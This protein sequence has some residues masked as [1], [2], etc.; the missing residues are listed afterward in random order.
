MI[1]VIV[2]LSLFSCS[3]ENESVNLN[4]NLPYYEFNN[5][6]FE[7]LLL[8][9]EDKGEIIIFKNQENEELHFRVIFSK[10]EKVEYRT[11]TFW[12]SYTWVEFYYDRQLIELELLDNVVPDEKFRFIANK[13]SENFIQ[14][15]INFPLWNDNTSTGALGR[16]INIDLDYSTS[17]NQVTIDGILYKKVIEFNSRFD[18]APFSFGNMPRNVAKIIYDLNKGIIGFNDLENNEWRIVNKI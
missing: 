6:D 1:Y 14:G 9:Y 16:P 15:G 18:V 17:V 7:N 4:E 13:Y 11:G 8:V 2:I 12:S 5:L 10:I 3:K